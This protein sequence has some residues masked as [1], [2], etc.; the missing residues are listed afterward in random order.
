MK[1]I[2]LLILLISLFRPLPAGAA[3]DLLCSTYPVYL[4]TQ[5]ILGD[6]DVY[7]PKLLIDAALGCP[8]DYN[9]TPADLERLS[10]ASVLVI[11]GL[12][13]E[14]FLGRALTVANADL[15][16]VDASGGRGPLA[17]GT[18]PMIFVMN[19]N[20]AAASLMGFDHGRDNHNHGPNAHMFAAPGPAA[21]MVENIAEGLAQI[22]PQGATLYRGNAAR[23]AGELRSLAELMNQ[24]GELLGHPKVIASHGIFEYLAKD[25]GLTVVAF[26]E[27]ED[28]AAPSAARLMELGR[29]ARREGVK[30]I[31]IDPQGDR[32]LAQTLGAEAKVPV[33]VIDLLSAGPNPAPPDYYL[34]AMRTNLVVLLKLLGPKADS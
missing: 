8:H 3:E 14:A 1:K 11:N 2:G 26:I 13:L 5:E 10:R 21:V 18:A 16:V 9:P 30:A 7:A 29:L 17:E 27:E 31:L 32:K 23:L 6:R 20:Q 19:R 33:A 12:G 25:M 24:N 22:D 34:K 4:F 28:G 15:K